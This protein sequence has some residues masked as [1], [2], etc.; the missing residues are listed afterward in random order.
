MT[1]C[2][3]HSTVGSHDHGFPQLPDFIIVADGHASIR[4]QLALQWASPVIS[5]S[6][7]SGIAPT[8]IGV[9]GDAGNCRRR[10]GVISA[11]R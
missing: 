3:A 9:V 5:V 10:T 4:R 1:P 6:E 7:L 2:P 8:K 11:M